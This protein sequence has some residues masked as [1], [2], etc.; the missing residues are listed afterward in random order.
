MVLV[1]AGSLAQA[2]GRAIIE[3]REIL[4]NLSELALVCGVEIT[5]IN[6]KARKTATPVM[7]KRATTKT[8]WK[9]KPTEGLPYGEPYGEP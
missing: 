1:V 6:K 2:A 4:R 3:G 5:M 7:V 9:P 8:L